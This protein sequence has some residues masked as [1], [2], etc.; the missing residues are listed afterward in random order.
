MY[1]CIFLTMC[2]CAIERMRRSDTVMLCC[3]IRS[4]YNC[5]CMS[6]LLSVDYVCSSLNWQALGGAPTRHDSCQLQSGGIVNWE[7]VGI[8][9]QYIMSTPAAPSHP[10]G[11]LYIA[12]CAEHLLPELS[13]HGLKAT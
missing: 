4:L 1:A 5:A 13:Y 11:Y 9:T 10:A 7:S 3:V 2:N 12:N 6:L 8:Q